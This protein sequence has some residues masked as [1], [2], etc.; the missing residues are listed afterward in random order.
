MMTLLSDHQN[1]TS[2]GYMY[3]GIWHKVKRCEPEWNPNQE[4]L[5]M[6]CIPEGMG[7]ESKGQYDY[8]TF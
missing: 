2:Q 4:T 8:S 5:N 1:E 6:C 3:D 7:K